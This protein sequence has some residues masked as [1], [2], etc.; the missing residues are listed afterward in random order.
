MQKISTFVYGIGQGLKNI[1][2]NRMFS[3]ASIATMAACLFLFG[4]CYSVIA[5]FRS[6]I[7]KAEQR[8]GITVFFDEGITD[9][10]I[11]AIGEKIRMR[12]EIAEIIFTSADQA[13]EEY[14][15]DKLSPELVETFGDDNPLE[16]SASYTVYLNDISMQ[17][18]LVRYIME[19]EGVRKV[20]NKKDVSENLTGINKVLTV[21]AVAIIVILLG[22]TIFLISITISTGV[23]IRKQEISIMKLIGATNFF[24]RIPYIVEGMIIGIIGAIIPLVILNFSYG[25]I[26]SA[27]QDNFQL[28][29]SGTEFVEGKDIMKVLIPVSLAIGIGIGFIGS[30]VTLGRQLRKIEVG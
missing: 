10:E 28:L 27:L 20:N 6:M 23:S 19:I 7:S 22:V 3:L 16:N 5:N 13:W 15:R 25:V 1:F 24:I 4:V 18:S 21:L 12:A 8:V 9:D 2:R 17:D 29:L 26:I 11:S 14:K 30:N